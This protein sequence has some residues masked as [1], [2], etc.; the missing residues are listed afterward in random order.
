MVTKELLRKKLSENLPSAFLALKNIRRALLNFIYRG[1]WKALQKQKCIQLDLGSG[2]NKGKNGWTTVDLFGADLYRDLSQ[3]IPLESN[4]VDVIYASHLLEHIQ[5]KEL[6][7]FIQEC[8]RVLKPGGSFLV[9]VPDASKYI[10]AY[11]GKTTFRGNEVLYYEGICNTGSFLDQV[12][13]IAYM[14]G[15]HNYLFDSENLRNTL[16]LADFSK[17]KSRTFDPRIDL[18]ARQVD[19]IYAVAEK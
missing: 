19:S 1:D 10:K 16:R 9:A 12:N 5:F 15:A 3:G 7:I 6:I 14:G 18:D 13:Y 17:V 8:H 2:S 4:S 11:L